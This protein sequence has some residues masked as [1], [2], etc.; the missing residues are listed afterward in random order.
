MLFFV[1]I[2]LHVRRL[3]IEFFSYDQVYFIAYFLNFSVFAVFQIIIIIYCRVKTNFRV[4]FNN[5][6]WIIW[7][8]RAINLLR[9]TEKVQKRKFQDTIF[10]IDKNIFNQ[11]RHQH[12]NANV[13]ILTLINKYDEIYNDNKINCVLILNCVCFHTNTH[14]QTE[15]YNFKICEIVTNI[16]DSL[17]I[18]HS[19]YYLKLKKIAKLE[20]YEEK[21]YFWV[22]FLV[23]FIL[24][25]FYQ[26]ISNIS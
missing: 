2:Y 10:N 24:E 17:T 1:Y 26:E 20:W 25:C 15:F 8:Y 12:A 13:E 18:L 19:I 6:L 3:K 4:F 23:R 16:F 21:I 7:E 22:I 11:Q 14:R 9:Q 5:M